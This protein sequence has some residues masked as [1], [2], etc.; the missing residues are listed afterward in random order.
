[1]A[2]EAKHQEIS[3]QLLA[4]IA[5]GKYGPGARLPSEAQLC[6][7]FE[8]ELANQLPKM[9]WLDPEDLYYLGFHFAEKE[10]QR[11]KLAALALKLVLKR[12]PRSKTAQAAKSKLR[13]EG[14]E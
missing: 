3:R 9:K 1:M 5:A 14:L 4:D 13:R 7:R 8:D 10:G 11:R 6:Q 2:S 12:S